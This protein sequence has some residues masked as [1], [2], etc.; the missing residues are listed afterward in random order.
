MFAV[1]VLVVLAILVPAVAKLSKEDSHLLTVPVNPLKVNMVEFVPAHTVVLPAMVP[2]TDA[3]DM[4]I[5]AELLFISL[6]T[7]LATTA[8]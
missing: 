8:L 6:Q 5:M 7:P 2:P 3:G 1:N 4:V